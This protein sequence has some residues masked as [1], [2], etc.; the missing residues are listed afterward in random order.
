MNTSLLRASPLPGSLFATAPRPHANRHLIGQFEPDPGR[1]LQFNQLL[2]HLNESHPQV[3]A[4]Q[5]ASAARELIDHAP[6]GRIPQSIRERIR[7]AGAIDLMQSD[8]EW[9]TEAHAAIAAATA[10]DYLHGKDSLIPHSLPVV[11]WLDGAVVIETAWPSLAEEV[12]D[13][14]DFCRLRRIEAGLRGESR[15]HFG[16]TRDQLDDART[17]EWLWQEH[18]LRTGRTRY[19]AEDAT[20]RFRVS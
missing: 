2:E 16:F 12:R 10:M 7:R 17:A 15:R 18:R 9:E 20:P 19:L 11:G 5:L 3:D 8:P 1:L 4:D 6:D 13:Y 14:L